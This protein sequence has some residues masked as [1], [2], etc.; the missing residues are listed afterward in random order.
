MNKIILVQINYTGD[1]SEKILPLGILSVGSVLKKN[2]YDVE[3]INI[4]EKEI[5]S[6]AF[7]VAAQNPFWVG[8]S[9]MTGI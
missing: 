4:N 5:D 2:G 3:L 9:V 1:H 6:I 7:R 8:L